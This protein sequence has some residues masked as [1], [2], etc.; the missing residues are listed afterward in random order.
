MTLKSLMRSSGSTA[1]AAL[2][3]ATLLPLDG[4]A[5][6]S[7]DR[8]DRGQW[9]QGQRGGN[10]GP[11]VN[12]PS[13]RAPSVNWGGGEVR[14]PRGDFRPR[15][16]E[17]VNPP[18][19]QVPAPSWSQRG[20]DNRAVATPRWSGER[21]A[22]A[23]DRA[24]NNNRQGDRGRDWSRNR[25]SGWQGGPVMGNN[26]GPR[27]G[28]GERPRDG[29]RGQGGWQGG[30]VVTP[31]NGP[32]ADDGQRDNDRPGWKSD[33]NRSY[34]DRDRNRS[35]SDHDR[36]RNWNHDGWRDGDRSWHHDRDRDDW[37]HYER[38]GHRYSYRGWSN[39]WRH[40][41]RYDWYNYRQSYGDI[42]R[43]G[44]YYSPYRHHSYSRLG[45]GVYLDSLFF[46]SNYWIDDPWRYRLPAAYGPYRWVRYYDDALLVDVYS[47]EVVD[48]VYDFFW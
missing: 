43:M 11:S 21:A 33:R 41:N 22:R 4:F 48:V 24:G 17:R 36:D 23:E 32:R 28:G 19:S 1:L 10:S 31:G 15:Q 26:D 7:A 27:G 2:L 42:Y 47:G 13:A 45:I 3:A 5:A 39:G 18:A 30:T 12:A 37:R 6:E 29:S 35:Y 44:R 9:S 25:G 38:D 34:A 14:M 8:G 20:S 40:D 46:G 16:I